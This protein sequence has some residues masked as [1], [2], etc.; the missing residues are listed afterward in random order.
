MSSDLEREKQELW[1]KI[2]HNLYEDE[3]NPTATENYRV[4]VLELPSSVIPA[5]HRPRDPIRVYAS[6]D[7][8]D[9][10]NIEDQTYW[11]GKKASNMT[12]EEK[13]EI[14]EWLGEW[15][16]AERKKIGPEDYEWFAT[17]KLKE[18]KP[19]DTSPEYD[20]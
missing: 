12:W 19:P 7:N 18:S 8:Y 10:V 16:Y 13:Q 5:K 6:V 20:Y 3:Y 2:Q 17:Q 4:Y 14:W 9:E 1:D 11:F 15:D